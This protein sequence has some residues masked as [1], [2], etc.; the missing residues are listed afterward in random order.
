[1]EPPRITE[2]TP[3]LI[4]CAVLP[5]PPMVFRI[6]APRSRLSGEAPLVVTVRFAPASSSVDATEGVICRLSLTD[7]MA[8]PESTRMPPVTVEVV[9]PPV[10][11][12]VIEPRVLLPVSV[13]VPPPLM[14]TLLVEAIEALVVLCVTLA[15]LRTRLPGTWMLPRA[16][17]VPPMVRVPWLTTVSPV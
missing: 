13:K 17:P 4:S 11:L 14:V 9:L 5:V 10:P 3:A 8:P 12:K 7:V 6:L 16:L 2:P 1:M 15:L